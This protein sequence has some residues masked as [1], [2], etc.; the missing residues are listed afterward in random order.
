MDAKE[1]EDNV[2]QRILAVTLDPNHANGSGATGVLYLAS[3]AQ[4]ND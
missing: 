1:L 3:L 4:V 2:L